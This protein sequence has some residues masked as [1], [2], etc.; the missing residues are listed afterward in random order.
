MCRPASAERALSLVSGCRLLTVREFGQG[1]FCAPAG[2][3]AAGDVVA[4]RVHAEAARGGGRGEA[5]PPVSWPEFRTRR[6]EPLERGQ[7]RMVW[8]FGE[9]EE[10]VRALLDDSVERG[11]FAAISTFHFGNPDFTNS[12][13]FL[14]R[15]RGRIPPAPSASGRKCR[16]P[17]RGTPASCRT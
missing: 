12:E 10:L 8:Q 7:G 2:A 11:G 9:N 5:S 6:I 14:H 3:R 1:A 15:W 13:P 17:R 4:G 16:A